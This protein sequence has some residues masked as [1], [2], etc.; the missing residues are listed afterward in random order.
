MMRMV[1]VRL[2][3]VKL[4]AGSDGVSAIYS[5]SIILISSLELEIRNDICINLTN[6][7]IVVYTIFWFLIA[8]LT[9]L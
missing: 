2:V 5:C 4:A 8:R 3:A 9:A 7:V 1:M 6:M